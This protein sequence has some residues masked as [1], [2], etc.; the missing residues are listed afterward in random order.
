MKELRDLGVVLASLSVVGG[1]AEDDHGDGEEEEEHTEFSH[2]GLDGQTEDAQTVRMLRQLE[3]TEHSQDASEQERT[4]SLLAARTH[5][6]R[7]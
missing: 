5:V 6:R 3:D 4:A 7:Q 2:A 1:R